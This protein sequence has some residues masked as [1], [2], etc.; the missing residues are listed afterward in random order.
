MVQLVQCLKK[1][2]PNNSDFFFL[3]KN[4]LEFLYTASRTSE[5]ILALLQL[6]FV[7]SLLFQLNAF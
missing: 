2:K 5:G 7:I 3:S 4:I 6:L 1:Y